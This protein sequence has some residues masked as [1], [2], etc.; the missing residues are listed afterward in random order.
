MTF[1]SFT[2]IG[3]CLITNGDRF[4]QYLLLVPPRG[5]VGG[6]SPEEKEE[7]EE[8]EVEQARWQRGVWL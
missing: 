4:S 7:K 1:F 6:V 3:G 8:T 2:S 5:A